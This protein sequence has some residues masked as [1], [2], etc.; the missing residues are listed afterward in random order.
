MLV[1]DRGSEGERGVKDN[2]LDNLMSFT[3][4]GSTGR[5]HGLG[6]KIM[7]LVFISVQIAKGNCVA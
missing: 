7:S 1:L 6:E 2:S 3:K 5:R 4:L